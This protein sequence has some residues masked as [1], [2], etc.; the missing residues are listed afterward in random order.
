MNLLIVNP[1]TSEAMTEDIRR[2]VEQ[3]KSPDVSVTVTGPDFGPEAL[4]SFYDYTLAAF[5]LCRLLEQK[6]EQYDGVLIAC[7][8][9]PGLYAC[10]LYTSDAA[11]E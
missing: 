3:A 10:L 9:D 8:G 2:T 4:E 1:N 11:D 6:T 5:G 7:Y